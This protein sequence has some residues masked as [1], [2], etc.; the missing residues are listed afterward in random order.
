MTYLTTIS[1]QSPTV[2]QTVELMVQFHA[3]QL[4]PVYPY[5]YHPLRTME[6]VLRLW[7]EADE[8]TLIAALFHDV[9]EDCKDK[10]VTPELLSVLGYP[11]ST[12]Q[13]IKNISK[14]ETINRPY[15]DRIDLIIG[16][17]DWRSILVKLADNM[18]NRHIERN[19]QFAE[20]N[21]KKAKEL[22]DRYDLSMEKLSNALKQLVPDLG[23]THSRVKSLLQ[24]PQPLPPL[25]DNRSDEIDLGIFPIIPTNSPAFN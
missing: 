18:D 6:N 5:F 2:E 15:Q 24:Y 4:D 14:N 3:E 13:I 12:I 9:L 8:E 20:E 10:D 16:I 25:P 21:P 17:G 11:E 1:R 23:I 19:R 22:A 7:P